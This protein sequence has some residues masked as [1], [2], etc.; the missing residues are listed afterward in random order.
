[1]KAA[2]ILGGA[3]TVD[4]ALMVEC[5][6]LGMMDRWRDMKRPLVQQ[7]WRALADVARAKAGERVQAMH[8]DFIE[9]GYLGLTDYSQVRFDSINAA[10]L[11]ALET[12]KGEPHFDWWESPDAVKRDPKCLDLALW[13]ADQLCGLCFATPSTGK[14]L[15]RI[16]LLEGNPD[17]LHP[18]KGQVTTLMLLA[19]NQFCKLVD[20]QVIVVED[21]WEGAIPHYLDLGFSFNAGRLEL[22]V[23]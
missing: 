8:R 23:D 11:L 14:T 21:P 6:R 1:M 17:E 13:F 4:G 12:W 9:R 16:K 15:V 3:C 7:R 22:A 10:A 20:A 18:L 2:P 5:P 19:V